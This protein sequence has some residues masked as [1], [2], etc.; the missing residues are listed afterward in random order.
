MREAVKNTCL[1]ENCSKLE[2]RDYVE[3]RVIPQLTLREKIGVMS[4]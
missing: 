3:N 2:I 4:G 1:T